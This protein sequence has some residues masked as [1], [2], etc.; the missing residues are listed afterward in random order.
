MHMHTFHR[1]R[2]AF[3]ALQQEGGDHAAHGPRKVSRCGLQ[4]AYECRRLRQVVAKRAVGDPGFDGDR[5]RVLDYREL[6]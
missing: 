6:W 1:L 5:R 2:R 3:E 4:L